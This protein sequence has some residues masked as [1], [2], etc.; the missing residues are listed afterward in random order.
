MRSRRGEG[1][2]RSG[3]GVVIY[4]GNPVQDSVSMGIGR[5][6]SVFDAGMFALAHAAKRALEMVSS[7]HVASISFFSHSASALSFKFDHFHLC[8]PCTACL[9]FVCP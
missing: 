9:L 3:D 8:S 6:S 7:G 2:K 1:K 4:R 5:R